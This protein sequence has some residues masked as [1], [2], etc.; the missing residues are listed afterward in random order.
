MAVHA[1]PDDE[2]ITGGGA[3]AK[4]AE[5][6]VRTVLVTCTL[7]EVGEIHDPD[8]EIDK[9]RDHLGEIRERELRRACGL[10]GV[11]QVYLLGY[12]DSGM[13]GT[14]DN[15]HPQ[16]FHR[17]D[18]NQATERLVG[19]MEQE[20]PEVVFTYGPDGGYPHPDHLKAHRVT[21]D[22]VDR[23]RA[24]GADFPQRLYWAVWSRSTI[25]T[26]ARMMRERGLRH[27]FGDEDQVEGGWPDDKITTLIDVESQLEMVHQ[28][29]LCHR[30]QIA[31]DG[32]FVNTPEDIMRAALSRESFVRPEGL[33]PG[34][35][36]E[37]DLYPGT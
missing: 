25:Q 20:R 30:T 37:T 7:G 3:L 10:L 14:A 8:L 5:R 12:R 4:Y 28:A 32:F 1:H 26:V 22:A 21:V 13:A 23:L 17:A 31:Q 35:P 9:V 27:P 16:S 33:A 34:A 19:I 2:C 11:S 24:A 36:L 18:L 29:L 6:G 15:D